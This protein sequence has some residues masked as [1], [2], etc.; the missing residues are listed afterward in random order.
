MGRAPSVT[1]SDTGP[2]H[3]GATPLSPLPP[4]WQW[5]QGIGVGQEGISAERGGIGHLVGPWG[6]TVSASFQ[7]RAQTS[8]LMASVE[9]TSLGPG[10][11]TGMWRMPSTCFQ[12][13]SIS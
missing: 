8:V 3:R 7:L 13:T 11:V 6:W 12:L 5:A 1:E 10:L 4:E 9:P 2:R